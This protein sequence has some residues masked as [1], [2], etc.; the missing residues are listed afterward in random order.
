MFG[1]QQLNMMFVGDKMTKTKLPAQAP[2]IQIK[3]ACP[4][5]AI[6]LTV[7]YSNKKIECKNCY[8]KII[9]PIFIEE[10]PTKQKF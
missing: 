8:G 5:C 1:V 6:Q 9:A 2:R 3:F 7:D 4:Y 10:E